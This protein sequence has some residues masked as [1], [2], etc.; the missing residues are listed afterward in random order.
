MPISAH[1]TCGMQDF[2]LSHFLN[3]TVALYCGHKGEVYVGEVTDCVDGIVTLQKDGK[4]T[5]VACD[6]VESLKA[7]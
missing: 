4:K 7:Q 6:K 5:F 3:T 1:A 2:L